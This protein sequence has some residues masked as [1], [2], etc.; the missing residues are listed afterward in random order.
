M[1]SHPLQH[2]SS[3]S[4]LSDHP[5]TDEAGSMESAPSSKES[6]EA[7]SLWWSERDG[8]GT[9]QGGEGA[10]REAAHRADPVIS[11]DDLVLLH[12]IGEGG[13][14]TTYLGAWTPREATELEEEPLSLAGGSTSPLS[15]GSASPVG[16]HSKGS[17]PLGKL[18]VMRRG[19]GSVGG[20]VRDRRFRRSGEG[21][22]E[23]ALK[24]AVKVASCQ[25]ESISQLQTELKAFAQLDHPNIV[26][27]HRALRAT[28]H[29]SPPTAA[30]RCPLC[31][32]P[33]RQTV[34]VCMY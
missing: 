2:G 17:T 24:V 32:P 11:V 25:G 34:T 1:P 10:M 8:T 3:H 20:K 16:V 9:G 30:S 33:C 27:L 12:R 23:G 21:A 28:A 4:D 13:F 6:T 26:K 5:P 22:E 29:R 14:S 15:S 7:A 31:L 19:P 18:P